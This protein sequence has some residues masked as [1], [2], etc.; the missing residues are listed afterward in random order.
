MKQLKTLS[1][2]CILAFLPGQL[3]LSQVPQDFPDVNVTVSD[4]PAPGYIFISNWPFFQPT[5]NVPFLMMLDNSG[6]PVHYQ[7][8]DTPINND[9]KMQPDGT[10]TYNDAMQFY[11]LDDT[12][13]PFDVYTAGNGRSTDTHELRVLPNGHALLL[14]FSM[15]T[16]DMTGFGGKENARLE[17]CYIQEVDNFGNVYWEWSTADHFD[18]LDTTPDVDKTGL[19]VDW[20]H[21]NAIDIDTD[22]NVLL[23]NRHLDEITKIDRTTGDIIWRLGGQECRNNQFTFTNDFI[24]DGVDTLFYGFSHQHAVRR[25][26]N[27]D[28]LLFDNGNLKNPHFSRAVEY[29]L[30]EVNFTATRVW[31]FRDSPDVVSE[32]MGYTQR[33]ENGNTLIGWGASENDIAVTEVRPDGSKA[34][35]MYFPEN[36]VS[37]RAFRFVYDMEAVTLTVDWPGEYD[38]NEPG[39]ETGVSMTIDSQVGSGDL[40]VQRHHYA[41]HDL[42]FT[43]GSEP[44]STWPVRWLVTASDLEGFSGSVSFD[45]TTLPEIGSPSSSIAY[46]R[47]SEG[48][49]DFSPLT[50]SYEPGT[51]TLEASLDGTGEF[52]IGYAPSLGG[53]GETPTPL[54]KALVMRQNW[55]NPF[56]GGTIISYDIPEAGHVRCEVYDLQGRR[57]ATLVD[58]E[59]TAGRYQTYFPMGDNA[60]GIYFYRLKFGDQTISRKMII[61]R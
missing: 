39:N 9:F 43:A 14:A 38:F 33:L 31:Q 22:G 35:E 51:G 13:Q 36:V 2:L 18:I 12:L 49:G 5:G 57:I 26:D 46:Y 37:Y 48:T 32:A 45:L 15:R 11:V 34:F 53:I 1:L 56:N 3:L 4:N 55:P 8:L 58:E 42:A 50:T 19:L 21:S 27:G 54:P 7:E 6:W 60:S 44:D 47:P 10:F 20:V 59:Q 29:S 17:D 25:L 30:D 16:A 23:S 28:I 52:V 41:A 61:A 24:V 40:T